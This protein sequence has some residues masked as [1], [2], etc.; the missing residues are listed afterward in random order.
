MEKSLLMLTACTFHKMFRG[1]L[2]QKV[3]IYI[4]FYF[5]SI[6]LLKPK[7]ARPRF[8]FNFAYVTRRIADTLSHLGKVNS[9]KP[10]HK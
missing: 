2:Q 4:Q 7:A 3:L 9:A 8:N 5:Q 1:K 10:F 6:S